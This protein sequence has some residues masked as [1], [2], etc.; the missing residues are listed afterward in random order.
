MLLGAC[1]NVNIVTTHLFSCV[2]PQAA[3]E[4]GVMEK[5]ARQRV[6]ITG[7]Y[8]PHWLSLLPGKEHMLITRARSP[9]FN[10]PQATV[11]TEPHGRWL[12][13]IY[14]RTIKF[15]YISLLPPDLLSPSSSGHQG[16]P[17]AAHY[18]QCFGRHPAGFHTFLY[19]NQ[20]TMYIVQP[21]IIL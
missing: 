10:C 14:R 16:D 8:S 5:R 17:S 20:N 18:F 1:A 7:G 2:R 13:T 6:G 11:T 3:R 19:L 4:S 12:A 15:E 21:K 9:P